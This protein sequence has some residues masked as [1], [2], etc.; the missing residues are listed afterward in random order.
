MKD[1]LFAFG[2]AQWD[3]EHQAA[4]GPLGFNLPTPAGIAT[5]QSLEPNAN[6]S[7]FLKGIGSLVG[8]PGRR[9]TRL[10]RLGPTP[11][12]IRGPAW[13]SGR[14]S[15]KNV[16]TVSNGYDWNYRMDW[17][18]TDH[19]VLTG[20]IIRE[21]S[22][23]TPDNFANPNALPNFQTE[24]SGH[25]EIVR[26]QWAR[27]ISSSLVNE[28]RFSYGNINFGFLLTPA[29]AASAQANLP[30]IEFGNDI[31]F[32]SIGVDSNYPQGRSHNTY[33]VQEA[34]SYS[35][36]RHTIKAGVDVTILSVQDT[37]ALNTRGTIEYNAGGG[38]NV[39]FARKFY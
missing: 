18:F 32:P 7:L 21:H 20:S 34:L 38:F 5:L 3:R 14:F 35:A 16:R 11:W 33:Q 29:T 2:A 12:E 37:L 30:W 4:T 22:S 28:L 15:C 17:H 31:N 8:T 25:T 23:L 26:A 24:Q 13:K 1:K 9:Q 19:D 36:N 10:F 6:I 39:H 27:T